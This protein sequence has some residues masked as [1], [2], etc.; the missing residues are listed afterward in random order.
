MAPK[1][2]DIK[3]FCKNEQCF[4]CLLMVDSQ[5]DP[6][7]EDSVVITCALELNKGAQEIEGDSCP[8]Y[9]AGINPEDIETMSEDNVKK[10]LKASEEHPKE[11]TEYEE[12]KRMYAY[13]GDS[14]VEV[15]KPASGQTTF[16]LL[17]SYV[18]FY[19][20]E[21]A[22]QKQAIKD[23]MD[24]LLGRQTTILNALKNMM[25]ERGDEVTTEDVLT[26]TSP[27][28][29]E[30]DEEEDEEFGDD[31]FIEEEEEDEEDDESEEDDEDAEYEDDEDEEEE[32]A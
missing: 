20:L 3:K 19:N 23:E 6:E 18:T 17:P 12:T 14:F 7:D 30:E 31:D 1:K 5:T 10:Q 21:V 2:N 29:I 15:T 24:R 25:S 9:Q 28:A 8:S 22:N 4:S 27:E 32:D 11:D 26:I 13:R 16:M